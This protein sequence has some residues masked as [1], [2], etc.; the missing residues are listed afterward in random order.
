MTAA[1]S[2][3]FDFWQLARQA[4]IFTGDPVRSYEALKRQW[5]SANPNADHTDYEQ[6]MKR[7][8]RIIGL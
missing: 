2:A 1:K 7:L 8:A 6:T 4:G 3:G 5:I